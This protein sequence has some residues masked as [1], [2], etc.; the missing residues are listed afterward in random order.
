MYLWK[1]KKVYILLLCMI[2][3]I[4]DRVSRVLHMST[5]ILPIQIL[6]E[7]A[8]IPLAQNASEI[9]TFEMETTLQVHVISSRAMWKRHIIT[10]LTWFRLDLCW[11][12]SKFPLDQRDTKNCAMWPIWPNTQI[13]QPPSIWSKTESFYIILFFSETYMYQYMQ[14]TC[15]AEGD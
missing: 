6:S 7:Y 4:Y 1:L 5:W 11:K 9:N 15:D 14:S 2:C 12:A 10:L 3:E 8:E 13:L